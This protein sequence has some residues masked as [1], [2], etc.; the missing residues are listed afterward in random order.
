MFKKIHVAGFAAALILG[1]GLVLSLPT[2]TGDVA[3]LPQLRATD[4]VA[5]TAGGVHLVGVGDDLDGFG[6]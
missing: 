3:D 2:S 4:G 5:D 6:Q 1:G